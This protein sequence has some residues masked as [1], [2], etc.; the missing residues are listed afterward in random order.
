MRKKVVAVI[1]SGI[2]LL[3]SSTSCNPV[4]TQS[5]SSAQNKKE[6]IQSSSFMQNK[7]EEGSSDIEKNETGVEVDGSIVS[8]GNLEVD[9]PDLNLTEDQIEVLKYFDNDYFYIQNYDSFQKYPMVYRE[10]QICLDGVVVKML[11]TNDETYK[12]VVCMGAYY[13]NFEKKELF[14]PDNQLVVISGQHPDNARIIEGDFLSFYGRYIDIQPFD[15]DGKRDYYP[16]I[17]VNY[18]A[19]PINNGGHGTLPIRFDLDDIERVAKIIF[20]NNIKLKDPV[21]GEDFELD[22]LRFPQYDFYLVTP[23]NQSNANFSSFEFCS[24]KG[25]IRDINSTKDIERTLLVSADFEHYIVNIFDR[26]LNLIYLEY[27]DRDFQK[28]WSREFKDVDT[29]SLD[30]TSKNIYL[31]ANND[32]YII[33][34]E[35]GKDQISPAMVGEKVKISVSKDGIIM[36]GAGDKDNIMKT[37]FEGNIIW[38]TSTDIEVASCNMIQIVNGTVVANLIH[39]KFEPNYEYV[40]KMIAVDPEGNIVSEFIESQYGNIH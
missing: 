21:C 12:C 26:N 17:T 10:T 9:N 13:L 39:E 24:Q 14:L 1:M 36:I 28:L 11:E 22:E 4:E 37:D 31:V 34:T 5:S 16:Y 40:S 2:L 35:T 29:L 27:Y 30:Y 20:G 15:V 23:D 8:W 38:K 32:L 33:D 19:P 18:A 3:L 7:E 6:E 25:F